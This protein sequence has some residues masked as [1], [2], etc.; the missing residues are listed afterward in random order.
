MMFITGILRQR[1]DVLVITMT[2][3]QYGAQLPLGSKGT[4]IKNDAVASIMLFEQAP[5][6]PEFRKEVT[7]CPKQ[8]VAGRA[9]GLWPT[10]ANPFLPIRFWPIHFC[11]MCC[12]VLGVVVH[13]ALCCCVLGVGVHCVVLGVGVGVGCWCWCGC[14]FWT[15]KFSP[16]P[17]PPTD[18]PALDHPTPDRPKFRSKVQRK[19]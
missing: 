17:D 8:N 12:C 16:A 2:G 11:V 18:P 1:Q 5:V 10:L 13:C 14:W 19:D 6:L 3:N 7:H 4:M 15:L 9:A